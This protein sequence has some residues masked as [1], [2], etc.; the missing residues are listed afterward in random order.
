M[1]YDSKVLINYVT[2]GYPTTEKTV[3]ILLTLQQ[4][5][6]DIIEVGVPFTDPI[7]DGPTI[8]TANNIAL[9]NGINLSIIFDLIKTARLRGVNIPIILMGYYNV[10]YQYGMENLMIKSKDIG[11]N[12]FIIVDL[13]PDLDE[14]YFFQCQGLNR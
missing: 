9:E 5:G 8:Q 3:D 1:L 12:G 7:A 13:P 4:N 10:F 11:I 14:S 2:A 6:T